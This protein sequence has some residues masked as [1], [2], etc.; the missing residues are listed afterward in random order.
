VR[1]ITNLITSDGQLKV[2]KRSTATTLIG[3]KLIAPPA[4]LTRATIYM[5]VQTE[6]AVAAHVNVSAVGKSAVVTRL[7]D[8]LR[9]HILA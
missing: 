7:I 3:A 5:S 9:K 6:T 4:I 8:D 1:G 2:S